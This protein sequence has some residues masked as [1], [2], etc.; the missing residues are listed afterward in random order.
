VGFRYRLAIE[1]GRGRF[2]I[3]ERTV[4]AL[5]VEWGFQYSELLEMSLPE[6]AAWYDTIV[7][8]AEARREAASKWREA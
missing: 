8:I 1:R 6:I 5:L 2:F 7:K 4:F 3:I